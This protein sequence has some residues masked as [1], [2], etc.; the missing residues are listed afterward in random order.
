MKELGTLMVV[1]LVALGL[2]CRDSTAID[3]VRQ[4]AQELAAQ[5]EHVRQGAQG[6]AAQA[7]QAVAR[8]Q[9]GDLSDLQDLRAPAA[10]LKASLVANDF[11]KAREYAEQIDQLLGT[12]FVA[13][14]IEFLRIE[15]TDGAQMASAAVREYMAAH[16]LG[17]PATRAFR[18]VLHAIEQST[19]QEHVG[20]VAF[21][22]GIA[23]SD[24]M[25]CKDTALATALTYL[26]MAQL[27]GVEIPEKDRLR[28]ESF[29]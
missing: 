18:E 19:P 8:I 27:F 1:P 24:K 26:V 28:W 25:G 11:A 20:T 16:E 9:A 13:Q 15:A 6:L 21:I 4:R 22:V 7:E 12:A 17:E 2:G 14:S 3:H 23:C 5:A 29:K 10:E